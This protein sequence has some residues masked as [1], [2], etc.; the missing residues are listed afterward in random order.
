MIVARLRPSVKS[1][2][3]LSVFIK[4]KRLVELLWLVLASL[5]AAL[6]GR[7][8][9]SLQFVEARYGGPVPTAW[10]QVRTAI[11]YTQRNTMAV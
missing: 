6:P 3:L 5:C 4:K 9:A 11:I 1:L 2:P 8:R 10:P 7:S